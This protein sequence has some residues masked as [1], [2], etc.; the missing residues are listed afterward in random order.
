MSKDMQL[1]SFN[2]IARWHEKQRRCIL[3]QRWRRNGLEVVMGSEENADLSFCTL[4][5]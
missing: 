4:A 5:D 1:A 2:D 3:I